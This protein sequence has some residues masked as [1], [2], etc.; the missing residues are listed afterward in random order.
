MTLPWYERPIGA[1][2]TFVKNAGR[3]LK[4]VLEGTYTPLTPIYVA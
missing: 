2:P 1:E 3:Y 4:F